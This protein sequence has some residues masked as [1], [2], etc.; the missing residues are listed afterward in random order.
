MFETIVYSAAEVLMRNPV[1]SKRSRA[2]GQC[3]VHR[4][5]NSSRRRNKKVWFQAPLVRAYGSPFD[6]LIPRTE[7]LYHSRVLF[8]FIK[9]KICFSR[10]YVR[11]DSDLLSWPRCLFRICSKN[12][13]FRMELDWHPATGQ[14]RRFCIRCRLPTCLFMS[15]FLVKVLWQPRHPQ[16]AG[17]VR[18]FVFNFSGHLASSESSPTNAI[19]SGISSIV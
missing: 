16:V 13:S 18:A 12:L 17:E 4:Y 9:I 8:T 7:L 14:D 2:E 1:Q 10:M 11:T 5:L 15:D 6:S 3:W 19:L